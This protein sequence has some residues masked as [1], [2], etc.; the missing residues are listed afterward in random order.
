MSPIVHFLVS[1]LIAFFLFPH[2]G[3]KVLFVFVS[4]VLVDIDHVFWYIVNFKEFKLVKMYK[5]F[6]SITKN[7]NIAAFK[8]CFFVF[9]T[10]E[11]F[12]LMAVL[13]F[14]SEIFFVLFLGLS[15]HYLL[16]IIFISRRYYWCDG[17][18]VVCPLND[19]CCQVPLRRWQLFLGD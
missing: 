17:W 5:Y 12:I 3:W 11:F 6:L 9:H 18:L 4:G 8:R 14:F 1:L 7:K 19:L 2:Y 15:S 10:A 16:D 13:S